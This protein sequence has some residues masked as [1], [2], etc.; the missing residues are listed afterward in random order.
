MS[1][2]PELPEVEMYARYLARHA[3]DQPITRIRVLDSRILGTRSLRP[4]VGRDDPPRFARVIFDFGN[5]AHLAY[6]TR[7]SSAWSISRARRN[8]SPMA[9]ATAQFL[10][11]ISSEVAVDLQIELCRQRHSNKTMERK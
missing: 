8:S 5:G 11:M 3:L 2:M 10:P 1:R 4:L 6:G 9:C 7:G